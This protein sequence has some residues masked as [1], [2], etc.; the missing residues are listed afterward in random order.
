MSNLYIVAV[1]IIF[2]RHIGEVK[3]KKEEISTQQ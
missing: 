2:S 1:P 3:E